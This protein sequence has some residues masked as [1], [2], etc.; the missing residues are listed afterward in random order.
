VGHCCGIEHLSYLWAI[1]AATSGLDP[2]PTGGRAYA[3]T[4]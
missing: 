2:R 4:R 1:G 3:R